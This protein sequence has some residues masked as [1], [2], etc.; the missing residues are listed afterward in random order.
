M[1]RRALAFAV[2]FA[3][4][5][6][7]AF[8][9]GMYFSD[10]GVRPM[11]RGGAFVAGADDLGAIWYNPA[12][13][14][15]VPS[16]AL[17]DFGWLRFSVDYTR[18][19]LV[20]DADDTYRRFTSPTV[21]GASPI[22]PIPTLA[23]SGRFG[24]RQRGTLAGG[25]L[26][27]YVAL[28][29]YA[30]TV[31]GQ[32]SP[33]RYTLGS[34]DGSLL[35]VPGIWTSYRV[36]EEL[37]LGLGVAALVGVFQST[38]TF[39]ASPQDRLLGAPE[40]PEYDADGQLRVGPIFSPT[41][42]AGITFVPSPYVR[43]GASG[44]LP[45][46]VDEPAKLK[47][48]MPTSAVFDN[49]V[50]NG[51]D[52]RV[53]FTLPA[54]LRVGL[55][56]RPTPDLRVEAAYVREFWRSHDVIEVA[57]EGMTLDHITGLPPKVRVPTILIPRSFED[58]HSLRLG[59]ELRHRIHGHVLDLRAGG[60]YETSAVPKD[61]LSLSSLDFRKFMIAAGASVHLDE[62]WRVDLLVAHLFAESVYVAPETAKI[63][64]INPIQGSADFEPVNGGWY[65]ARADLIGLGLSYQY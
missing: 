61:Y 52:V 30:D 26:A 63:P 64:R 33:A 34:F 46:T 53:R 18:E 3:C 36:S 45:I 59:A 42:S 11:G 58:S 47:V 2:A 62:R 56:V 49:A 9:A 13:L 48:R 31:D 10:R 15:D 44:Q 8:A 39:S 28:A 6:S 65:S 25:I 43:V 27:P 17:A 21:E 20:L 41:A 4:F 40:Q 16:G 55:E 37:R 50:Q 54:V 38:V 23:V 14:C 1:S 60:S 5:A 22:L 57:E 7:P 35:A 32:P 29:S 19:L 24:A 51:D 12:G